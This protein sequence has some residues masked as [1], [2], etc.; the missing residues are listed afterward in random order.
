[1]L[2]VFH[3]QDMRTAS[4]K[5]HALV[6]SLR[7]KRP[8]AAYVKMEADAWDRTALEGHLGGQGLFSSKYIVFLDGVTENAAA[9][10]ELPGLVGPMNESDNIFIVLESK[11]NAELKKAFDEYAEKI[12]VC[13]PKAA[14]KP[15]EEFNA[16]TIANAVARK[17]AAGAW[18]AYREAIDRGTEPENVAGILFWKAKSTMDRVLAGKLAVMYHEAHRGAVNLESAIER[19]VLGL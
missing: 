19:L 15:K 8:D 11:P 14:T 18:K 17:D 5:A 13:E 2:Y 9:K 6:D 4:E 10:A 16:F 12:V 3:G 1:M 7:K